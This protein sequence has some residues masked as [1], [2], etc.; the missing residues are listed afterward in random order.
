VTDASTP[1][2]V[3]KSYWEAE[4]RRDVDA[5][6][7]HYHADAELVVPQLGRLA[8]HDEIKTFYVASID[9]FPE[10]KV[11]IDSEMADGDRGVFEWSSVFTDHAGREWKSN[12]V[13]VIRVS[14]GK[15]AS[16]H[17]YYDPAPLAES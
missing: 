15:F 17:V 13:N 2:I 14:E 6:L 9:R 16:V 1:E 7:S 8:G 12:G 10:L 4:Q 3:V 5:V 11:T